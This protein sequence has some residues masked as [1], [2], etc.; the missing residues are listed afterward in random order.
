[1]IWL[2]LFVTFSITKSGSGYSTVGTR[3][4]RDFFMLKIVISNH[5]PDMF[6]IFFFITT[7]VPLSSTVAR[8]S[9]GAYSMTTVPV[10]RSPSF[11]RMGDSW[12]ETRHDLSRTPT[13]YRFGIDVFLSLLKRWP[14]AVL[15]MNA[16]VLPMENHRVREMNLPIHVGIGTSTLH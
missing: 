14:R 11:R 10:R 16:Q 7:A 8:N 12:R 5:I 4:D 3:S 13:I 6:R 9:W 2:I 15:W 1:M